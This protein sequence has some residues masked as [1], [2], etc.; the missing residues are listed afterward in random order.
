M[1]WLAIHDNAAGADTHDSSAALHSALS[2]SF[3]NQHAIAH[4]NSTV[5]ARTCILGALPLPPT[6]AEHAARDEAACQPRSLGWPQ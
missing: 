4:S 6:K 5:A 2:G 3:R 1:I